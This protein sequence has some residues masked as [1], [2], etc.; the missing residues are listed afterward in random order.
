MVDVLC[1]LENIP[2]HCLK[3]SGTERSH[4]KAAGA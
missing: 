1:N 2:K 3:Q 4:N